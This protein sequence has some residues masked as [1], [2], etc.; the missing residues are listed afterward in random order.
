MPS[1]LLQLGHE[2]EGPLHLE[3][4]AARVDD[5]GV[6]DG[7]GGTLVQRHQA[8]HMEG[9][10]EVVALGAHIDQAVEGGHVGLDPG[11]EHAA[12][13]L[14]GQCVASSE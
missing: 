12:Q 1:L 4:A 13:H 5:R 11:V 7:V 3:R 14:E 9:P 2:L 8:Q 10:L 6:A